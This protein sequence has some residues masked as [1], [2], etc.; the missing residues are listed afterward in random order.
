MKMFSFHSSSI[1][2]RYNK[3]GGMKNV[4]PTQVPDSSLTYEEYAEVEARRI[5][6]QNMRIYLEERE[7]EEEEND[8][9]CAAHKMS[10]ED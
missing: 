5:I 10:R 8:A 9:K 1:L 6:T 7:R 2:E 3:D 4:K